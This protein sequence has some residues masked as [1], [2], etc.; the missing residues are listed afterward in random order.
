MPLG[1]MHIKWS[2]ISRQG[3]KEFKMDSRLQSHIGHPGRENIPDR[4][5]GSK[6]K[7]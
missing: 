4:N 7:G 2:E 6:P 3:L 1:I 5:I